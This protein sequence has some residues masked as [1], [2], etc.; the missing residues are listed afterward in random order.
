MHTI[1]TNN[2]N[3]HTDLVIEQDLTNKIQE[4]HHKYEDIDV[5]VTTLGTNKYTT[6]SF[7][8]ITDKDNFKKVQNIFIKELKSFL[9]LKTEDIFLVIGLGNS[10][11]T[12][13]SLGPQVVDNILVT[14][15]LF[16]LGDVEESYS[17]VCK[18]KPS[19]TGDTGIETTAILKSV[20]KESKATKVIIID[21]LKASKVSRL[22]KIIQIT[23]SGIHPGS[24]I[25]NNRGEVSKKTMNAEIIAIGVPTVVDVKTIIEDLLKEE[26]TLNENLIVTPTNIDFIIEKLGLLIGNGIN[27]TLHQ[28]F[29]RQNNY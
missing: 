10:N 8:D 13:D 11:S 3:L 19:V 4:K 12:P 24:G 9:D 28:D 27:I 25:N 6:I 17:N 1:N 14:R 22:N 20:I 16:L 15:H 2:L 29:K 18:F 26:V 23:N 7:T 21:S 5:T